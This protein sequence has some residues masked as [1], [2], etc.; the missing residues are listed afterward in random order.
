MYLVYRIIVHCLLL[1][2]DRLPAPVFRIPPSEYPQ[3]LSQ[4]FT[5]MSINLTSIVFFYARYFQKDFR[6]ATCSDN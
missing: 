4:Q 5:N 2:V 6:N 3:P 1:T